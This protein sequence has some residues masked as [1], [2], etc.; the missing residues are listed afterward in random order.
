MK[1]RVLLLSAVHPPTDPRI[2][3]KIGPSLTEHYEVI[4]ALPH[5]RTN[6]FAPG[7][8][9]VSLPYFRRLTLR[10]LFTHPV[11]L[12]KCL[13]LRPA[14]V[15][16]FVPEL[17][18]VA[19]LFKWLGANV[20]YEVQENLF[21]KF[22]IKTTNN[23]I[24]YRLL[25]RHLDRIARQHFHIVLTESAY[26]SVYAHLKYPASVIQNYPSLPFLD[27]YSSAAKEP[28]SAPIFYYSG[29][30]SMERS[31]D[32]LVA[33]LVQLKH[34]HARFHVHMFGPVRFSLQQAYRLPGYEKIR[35]HITLHGYTDLKYSL[36]LARKSIAGIALLKPVADYP[37]S[38]PTKLFEYM[39]QNLP[40]ITSDYPLYRKV[41]DGARCGFCISPYDSDK[42][43]QTLD[44]LILNPKAA[45]GLGKNG[46]E[47]VE[48][49]YN[50]VSEEEVLFSLYKKIL[51]SNS[52]IY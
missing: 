15:H 33:A 22:E 1:P 40:V 20:I 46:R 27:R 5:A 4:C 19:F 7:I 32:T 10:L 21:K 11:V 29:V 49:K 44:W 42:L 43:S 16:I 47:A 36:S 2:V 48:K 39:A 8:R 25:F 3:Y 35:D 24:I 28:E 52:K 26:L 38:Y 12:L 14:V 30:V 37:E 51:V 9:M 41:V 23:W 50:W 34:K 6:D 45:Q 31:F 18:P 17:I 13:L